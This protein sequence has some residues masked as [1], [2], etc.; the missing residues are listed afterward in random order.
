MQKHSATAWLVNTGWVGGAYGVG[1]RIKLKY[2]R[3]ML[4]AIHDG[5]LAKA[6]YKALDIFGLQIPVSCPG[7]PDEVLV[8]R[9]AWKDQGKYEQSLKHLAE[10]FVKN[11]EKYK[12]GVAQEVLE[13]GP[14]L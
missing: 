2:T 5:T 10:M 14:K 12:A 3:A 13:A 11:F 9:Q 8:P 1:S 4:D 6:E 7:V